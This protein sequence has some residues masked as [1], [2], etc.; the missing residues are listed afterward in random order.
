[1]SGSRYKRL[2]CGAYLDVCGRRLWMRKELT[3]KISVLN[4]LSGAGAEVGQHRV[5]L[6]EHPTLAHILQCS[7]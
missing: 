2:V 3:K 5:C 1:M 6:T 7:I 4:A